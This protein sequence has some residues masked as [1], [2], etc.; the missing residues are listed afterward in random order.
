MIR[1]SNENIGG[2]SPVGVGYPMGGYGGGF[3]FGGEGGIL[4]LIALL[5]LFRGNLFGGNHGEAC[6]C[7]LPEMQNQ[8]ANLR[9]DTAEISYRNAKDMLDQIAILSNQYH[10]G[11]YANAAQIWGLTNQFQTQL[12]NMQQS[13]AECCCLTNKNIDETKYELSKS[14][15]IQGFENQLSNCNQTN[16]LQNAIDKC[17]CETNLNIER[18]A[19]AT[20]LRDLECCCETQKQFA[21]L[22]AG[23]SAIIAHVDKKFAEDELARLK[24]KVYELEEDR[25]TEKIIGNL[26]AKMGAGFRTNQAAIVDFWNAD[27]DATP[28]PVFSNGASPIFW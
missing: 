26:S 20:Q 15:L 22:K 13:M 2:A 10:E 17:C 5:A 24:A 19:H 6:G 16:T 23:Q 28:K 25:K 18:T 3:G 4:G 12:S 11:K 9:H 8:L 14:I 7:N 21:E 27:T 1:Y